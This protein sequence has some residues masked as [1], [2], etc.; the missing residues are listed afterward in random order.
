MNV[1]TQLFL[2]TLL[3]SINARR[4]HHLYFPF[5]SLL[6]FVCLFVFILFFVCFFFFLFFF[7]FIFAFFFPIATS[8]RATF[9]DICNCL[10]LASSQL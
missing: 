2:T 4:R 1:L 6:F 5:L 7:V 9:C 3:S 10:A 8:P